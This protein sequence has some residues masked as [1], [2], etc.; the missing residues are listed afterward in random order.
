MVR[1]FIIFGELNK[2]HLLLLAFSLS[3]IAHKMYNRYFYP[4]IKSNTALDYY[5]IS[6]GMMSV[7]FLPLIMKIKYVE[8]E[9]EKILHKKKKFT[10]F[11]IRLYL[12]SL[13]SNEISSSIIERNICI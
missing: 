3:Q 5:V 12:F 4:S 6:F 2:K 11:I 10:F 13:Y 8:S 7:V 9:K 1:K